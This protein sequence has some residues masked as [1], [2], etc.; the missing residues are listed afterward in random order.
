MSPCPPPTP[1]AEEEAPPAAKRIKILSM[2]PQMPN[3]MARKQWSL[4]DYSIIRKMYTGYASTV[5]Q[6]HHSNLGL[7]LTLTLIRCTTATWG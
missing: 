1:Q 4:A 5:Y 6:V 7:A 2:A 3:G